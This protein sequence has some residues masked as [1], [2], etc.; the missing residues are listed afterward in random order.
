MEI[1]Y[2]ETGNLQEDIAQLAQ[3]PGL[4][5]MGDLL[6]RDDIDWQAVQEVH[7]QWNKS[8]SGIG[9]PGMQLVSLAMAVAL[10]FIPG[11]QGVGAGLAKMIGFTGNKAVAAAMA[12]GFNSLVMQAG[13]QVVGNGGDIGAA[14]EGLASI[15]TVRSLATAMLTAGLM[16]GVSDTDFMTD[17]LGPEVEGID[18]MNDFI[19]KLAQELKEGG[20]QAVINTGAGTAI[21]GGDLG[22][23][24][25][26]NL[27]GAAVS[28][29]GA[30][31][32]EA[33]GTAYRDGDIN[34][35][36][37]YITHAALGG[38][39]DI[40]LGGD[41]ASGAVGAVAGEFVGDVFV[42]TY[43]NEKLSNPDTFSTAEDFQEEAARLQA[44]GVD[45]AKLGAGLAAAAIGGDIDTAAQTGGNAAENNAVFCLAIAATL[46]AL[47]VA[48]KAMTAY[49][50]WRLAKALNDGDTDAAAEIGGE[51]AL[52]LATEAVPGNKIILSLAKTFDGLGLVALGTKMIGKF[53][54]D[55]ASVAT[56]LGAGK[57]VSA[58]K[59]AD[60]YAKFLVDPTEIRFTQ[61]SISN[62]FKDGTSVK[63]LI[64]DLKAGN[65]TSEDIPAIRVFEKDGKIYSLDNRRLKAFQD[66][67]V[68]IRI[69]KATNK[70]VALELPDKFTTDTDGISII[71][72]GGYL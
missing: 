16:E 72:R 70:E 9:G 56:K 27:H 40:A 25:V 15:D 71:V 63:G 26:A 13:M 31:G 20:V 67:G 19:A 6:E 39:M 46:V 38:A 30:A 48:D 34:L 43:V 11:T 55:V 52:G 45:L 36:S 53:G 42:E 69:Q 32:A 58:I 7:N 50:A 47:E 59:D 62:K 66:A 14:L 22:E 57:V 12:A 54:D 21:Y 61:D 18:S 41:G 17:F 2:R 68:P 65:I 4:A 64:D 8:D 35:A 49:D 24:L 23:N 5:W 3:A 44:A 29:F 51:I 1:Q 37:K 10:H 60:D 28:A 33:I